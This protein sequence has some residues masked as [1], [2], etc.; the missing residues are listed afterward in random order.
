MMIPDEASVLIIE[1]EAGMRATLSAI[2]EDTGYRVAKAEEGAEAMEMIKGG[3]F[4][5]IISDIRLPDASGTA[6]LELAKEIDPEV[7]VILITG[8]ASIETAVN[9]INEGAY[10]YFTKPI[11]MDEMKT[12]IANA[13][14]QQRLSRENKKLV[15]DLQRSNKLLSKA[16]HEL[17][18]YIIERQRAEAALRESEERYRDLFENANDLIQSVRPDGHYLYVNNAW[19][20]T[21]GYSKKE[22]TRLTLWDIIHPDDQL[23]C[24]ET[25]QKVMT[26]GTVGSI[27]SVFV[28]KDGTL[29]TVEGNVNHRS[30]EGEVIATRGIFRDITERKH[31]ERLLQEK[32]EALDA[33]NEELQ[34][35]SD[36]LIE[37]T[38]ALETASQFKSQFLAGMSHELRTPLNAVIGFSDLMLN[39]AL[40][41]TNDTQRQ[42]LTDILSS[43]QHLLAL[44]NDVLDLTKVEAGKLDMNPERL[45]L[46]EVI[47]EVL[48]TVKPLLDVSGLKL[49]ISIEPGLPA[50]NADKNRLRQIMLNL[51]SNA[52]KFTLPGG[53]IAVKAVK[54]DNWC[55]VSVIDSGIGIQKGDQERIFEAF[56]QLDT[57][58]EIRKEGTGLGLTITRQFVEMSGG[59]LWLESEPGEGSN[60]TFTLPF[61]GN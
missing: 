2:L 28:A 44:I 10:A 48:P 54:K 52:V 34:T 25:F 40:G 57:P 46:G 30:K 9:A 4:D 32:N 35:Q 37:K 14:R 1:D 29:L 20:K 3:A 59:R 61:A 12:A 45:N 47:N 55:Q 15:D 60:F 21:L 27:E 43:G 16:N 58:P 41:E 39:G 31:A 22:V 38:R 7:A 49:E 42:C 36:E 8:Y 26:G 56:N 17:K 6:I 19:R 50:V 53:K 33:Q 5:V 11:N 13:L 51:L 18:R 24:Q 23:H